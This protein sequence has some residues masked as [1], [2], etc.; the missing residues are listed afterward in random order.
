MIKDLEEWFLFEVIYLD[1]NIINVIVKG[2]GGV[3]DFRK[4]SWSCNIGRE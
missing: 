4:V 3:V 1:F 2:I